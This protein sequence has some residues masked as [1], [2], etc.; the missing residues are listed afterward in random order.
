MAGGVPPAP[1]RDPDDPVLRKQAHEFCDP[2]DDYLRAAGI[3]ATNQEPGPCHT[4][5]TSVASPLMAPVHNLMPT[6]LR[7]GEMQE[8]LAG[9]GH[10]D[11]QPFTGPLVDTPCESSR[12]RL[13]GERSERG[14]LF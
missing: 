3:W 11:F 5:V 13:V 2:E 10:R 7:S 14:E 1:L 8:F 12:G 9:S 6:L 4:M